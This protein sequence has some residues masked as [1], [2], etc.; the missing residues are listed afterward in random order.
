MWTADGRS[1]CFPTPDS[2][3]FFNPEICRRE[4]RKEKRWEGSAPY[5]HS[6]TELYRCKCRV[7][8]AVL[9]CS[10]LFCPVLLVCLLC[11]LHTWLAGPHSSLCSESQNPYHVH[12]QTFGLHTWKCV[13]FI[14]IHRILFFRAWGTSKW[15]LQFQL[16]PCRKPR[17]TSLQSRV[18]YVR[19][20]TARCQP[21]A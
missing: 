4:I 20:T 7:C 1:V 18:V 16:L 12:T 3:F 19:H 14:W 13:G 17:V 9:S 21:H 5:H 6:T 10:A 2:S 8:S 15:Y 11:V